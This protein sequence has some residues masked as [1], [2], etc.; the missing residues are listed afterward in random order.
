[1]RL[2]L[3]I[4]T[5]S[6]LLCGR[7]E[8]KVSSQLQSFDN[9]EETAYL[10]N[11][12][13]IAMRVV[14]DWISFEK[15]EG[16]KHNIGNRRLFAKSEESGVD[17]GTLSKIIGAILLLILFILFLNRKLSRLNS[18]I[19]K[20]HQKIQSLMDNSGQGILTF[21]KEFTVLGGYSKECLAIFGKKD[22]EGNRVDSLL[23]DGQYEEKKKFRTAVLRTLDQQDEKKQRL[24]ISLLPKE[25]SVGKKFVSIDYKILS[26]NEMMI[27]L[28][29]I[30]RQK[31][32]KKKVEADRERLKLIVS[33]TRQR[34]DVLSLFD[35]Y[36]SFINRNFDKILESS[37]SAE[38]KVNEIYRQIHTYKGLFLQYDFISIP[39]AL[40]SIESKIS[41]LKTEDI[42][43]R[44]N[45][46]LAYRYELISCGFLEKDIAVI[47]EALGTEFFHR[48]KQ[49]KIDEL[50]LSGLEDSLKEIKGIDNQYIVEAKL[51]SI[52]KELKTLRYIGIKS[53]LS[54][55]PKAVAQLAKRLEKEVYPLE[56]TGENIKIDPDKFFP[57][58]KTL[59][60]IFRN[61]LV[62][63]IETADERLEA[64]KDEKAIVRCSIGEING[65]IV[66]EISDDGRGI[67][68]EKIK[69]RALEI[70]GYSAIE[71]Q[72][73]I[74]EDGFSTA[75]EVSVHAGRG[76]GLAAVKKEAERLNGKVHLSSKKGK[77][78][79]FKII[80]P[81][82]P[83][84]LK[85]EHIGDTLINE[86]PLSLSSISHLANLNR[87]ATLYFYD[88]LGMV[89]SSR[90][91]E[92]DEEI[93]FLNDNITVSIALDKNR[94]K[95]Y[96][97]SFE[98]KF[99]EYMLT[100]FDFLGEKEEDK[101]LYIEENAMEIANTLT[102]HAL[103]GFK[104]R[105]VFSLPKIEKETIERVEETPLYQ[106]EFNTKFGKVHIGCRGKDS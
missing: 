20:K 50:E 9:I 89:F 70:D 104:E 42:K 103:A 94:S 78:T 21:S 81:N 82:V 65:L 26:F 32:L 36:G 54:S 19:Q 44:L 73:L 31:E 58:I 102:G 59:G 49:Y 33:S 37:E 14:P 90:K 72:N 7:G 1:M 105:I 101:R 55:Y 28:T 12:K 6:L 43:Y 47:K 52:L 62:H 3:L 95:E 67:D 83:A 34:E 53:L 8:E 17:Y 61:A 22:I 92:K 45:D 79:S 27:V 24:F 97:F 75:S 57:L 63:G 99:L 106:Y 64:G 74:F 16:V 96:L 76:V 56:I 13:K 11:K 100:L 68:T 71:L 48:E 40:H 38:E 84:T 69:K 87:H 25:I 60:H 86:D 51:K 66:I 41:Q 39:K 77:G 88:T 91:I 4:A 93:D 80:V 15:P 35:D 18:I 98:P 5:F 46:L 10:K 2:L 85:D 23:F 29:D 30:S